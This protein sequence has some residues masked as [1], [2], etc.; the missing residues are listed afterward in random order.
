MAGARIIFPEFRDEQADSKYPFADTASL[1]TAGDGLELPRDGIIDAAIYAINGSA[2]AYISRI[3]VDGNN[4]TIAVGDETSFDL[5]R[6][7]Y[8]PLNAPSNGH[9]Y[10]QDTYGR[11]AGLLILT[12]FC[13]ALFGGWPVKTHVF[14]MT[15]SEFV[16]SVVVPARESCVRA[17]QSENEFNFLTG[18]VWLIG[19]DGIV[20]RQESEA[21][22]RI[23]INGEPLFKRLLCEGGDEPYEPGPFLQT[24]NGCGPDEYGN[25]NITAMGQNTPDTVLRIYPDKNQLK[26]GLVGKKVI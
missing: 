16:S 12:K 19:G 6:V 2:R 4:V 22:V 8:S 9:L 3:V 7:T 26:I 10:L 13:L 17:I 20:V 5:A 15:D 14:G 18:D 1:Q 21:V 11:P 24:I 23:D 25:F